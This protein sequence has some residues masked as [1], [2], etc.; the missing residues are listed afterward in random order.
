VFVATGQPGEFGQRDIVVGTESDGQVPVY[1]GIK[2]GERVV[3]DGSF[4][5]RSESLKQKPDQAM[6][7]SHNLKHMRNQIMRNYSILA[8][9]L[10]LIVFLFCAFHNHGRENEW[11]ISGPEK[12]KKVQEVTIELT[13]KGYE[14]S[15]LKLRIGIPVRITFIRKIEKPAEPRSQFQ[16]S[17]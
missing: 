9:L 4:L 11:R 5:L 14:P 8:A 10:V 17:Q 13:E 16:N 7:A 12:K 6:L 3:T 15:S 2:A 1:R